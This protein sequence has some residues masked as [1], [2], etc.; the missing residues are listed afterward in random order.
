MTNGVA[1]G[2]S[3]SLQMVFSNLGDVIIIV[4]IIAVIAFIATIWKDVQGL[5]PGAGGGTSTG[6]TGPGG[7]TGTTTTGGTNITTPPGGITVPGLSTGQT[8]VNIG[9][10]GYFATPGARG[11]MYANAPQ[12][13][14]Y[15]SGLT[16]W[17]SPT[18]ILPGAN[19]AQLTRYNPVTQ[20]ITPI[21]TSYAGPIPGQSIA[22]VIQRQAIEQEPIVPYIVPPTP[23]PLPKVTGAYVT[24]YTG[25][26]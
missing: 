8:Y 17:V 26:H 11:T 14:A 20:T 6:G 12:I 3:E 19:Y 25:P 13:Q 24:S 9:G 21:V 1:H 10:T 23:A 4:I 7:V 5:F 2:L 15:P 22:D 18:G 16:N